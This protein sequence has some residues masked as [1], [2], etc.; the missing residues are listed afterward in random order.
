MPQRRLRA[1]GGGERQIQRRARD[2]MLAS[3]KLALL[4]GA[5]VAHAGALPGQLVEPRPG[6]TGWSS[7]LRDQDFEEVIT[8]DDGIVLVLHEAIEGGPGGFALGVLV[9]GRVER[10]SEI[11]GDAQ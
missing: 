7:L 10:P 6:S 11:A 5:H 4:L 1:K 9:T 2:L 8:P 3:R